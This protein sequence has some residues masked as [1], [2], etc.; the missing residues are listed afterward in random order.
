MTPSYRSC[1]LLQ[2][3]RVYSQYSYSQ[4]SVRLSSFA[5]LTSRHWLSAIAYKFLQWKECILILIL[6]IHILNILF[7]YFFA[8]LTSRHWSSYDYRYLLLLGQS[9]L[10]DPDNFFIVA[11]KEGGAK[12]RYLDL[13]NIGSY[14]SH[15]FEF[16]QFS[17][18]FG[19]HY[20]MERQRYD[21]K[22]V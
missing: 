18:S 5:Q 3:K 7:N 9:I 19:I 1:K 2:W 6:N 16:Y 17:F 8:Q 13:W 4:Y 20:E 15:I 10:W 11:D 12:A 22:G 21:W 14:F